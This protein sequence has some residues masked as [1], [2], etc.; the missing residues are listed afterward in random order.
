MTDRQGT[1][2]YERSRTGQLLEGRARRMAYYYDDHT[3]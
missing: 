3:T 1:V 2:W